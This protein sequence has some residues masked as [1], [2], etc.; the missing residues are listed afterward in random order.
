MYRPGSKKPRK[1]ARNS[2]GDVGRVRRLLATE[3]MRPITSSKLHR[4]TR[5]HGSEYPNSSSMNCPSCAPLSTPPS[6][7]PPQDSTSSPRTP[8]HP[9]LPI[10]KSPN[11]SPHNDPALSDMPPP[12]TK[13]AVANS[14]SGLQPL[15]QPTISTTSTPSYSFNDIHIAQLYLQGSADSSIGATNPFCQ[16]GHPLRLRPAL[17]RSS[18]LIAEMWKIETPRVRQYYEVMSDMKKKPST[19]LDIRFHTFSP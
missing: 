11:P 18:R 10:P 5:Y 17:T 13:P 7:C 12:A 14:S 4:R 6:P 9:A 16:L 3:W 15:A 1:A 2:G 19:S 8:P